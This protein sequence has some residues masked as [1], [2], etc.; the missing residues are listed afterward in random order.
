MSA[1]NPQAQPRVRTGQTPTELSKDMSLVPASE[2]AVIDR[3]IGYYKPYATSHDD[4]DDEMSIFEETRNAARA[5]INAMT[6]LRA[7]S[8]PADRNITDPR[9]K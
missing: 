1:D 4:L 2:S 9:P 6:D 3:Y 5:L 8:T 7:G